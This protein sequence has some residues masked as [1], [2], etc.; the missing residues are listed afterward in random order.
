MI[1]FNVF[2]GDKETPY[3]KT[4]FQFGHNDENIDIEIHSK[5]INNEIDSNIE[6]FENI[7][8][9]FVDEDEE[10]LEYL[11]EN[12]NEKYM[13]FISHVHNNLLEF[14]Y[15]EEYIIHD[16]IKNIFKEYV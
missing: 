12:M 11:K 2:V 14:F 16:G 5:I 4:N 6:G 9:Y 7:V 8:H 3:V 13:L 1:A 15:E 10:Q